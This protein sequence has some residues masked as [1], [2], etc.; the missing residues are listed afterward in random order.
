[1][2]KTVIYHA[3]IASKEILRIPQ[4]DRDSPMKESWQVNPLEVDQVI[5]PNLR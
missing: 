1:M 5:T 3:K 2:H 4:Q